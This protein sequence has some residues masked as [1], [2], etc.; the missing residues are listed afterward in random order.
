MKNQAIFSFLF[1]IYSLLFS[2]HATTPHYP[3]PAH[4]T[5]TPG[6][7]K[8]TNV[9]QQQMDQVVQTLYDQWKQTYLA[10]S[11]HAPDQM[12]VYYK[13]ATSDPKNAVCVSEGQGYGMIIAAFMAGYEPNAQI[14]F[15]NLFRYYQ[16]FPSVITAPLM[17]WQ[18]VLEEGE[19]IPNPDGGD[20]SA[21]DGDLDIAFALL[22]A[23]KQ[24]GSDN[25]PGS[26][27]YLSHAREI[28]SGILAGDVNLQVP[29]LKLGDWVSNC[30]NKFGKATRP[31]DFML[32][33][34]RNFSASS[35]DPGWNALLN[36]TYNI[37]NELFD[38]YSPNTGLMPDFS[39]NDQGAYIPA[40]ASFLERVED[41]YYSWNACRT[42]WRISLDYILAGDPRALDQLT[43]LNSWIQTKTSNN[44][45]NIKSGYKLDGMAL[46]SYGNLAF[47]TPFAVSAMINAGNQNWLN[48]LWTFTSS[49]PTSGANYFDNTLRLLCLIAVSGNWWTPLNLPPS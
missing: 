21:T 12:Y 43:Q 5:Y 26:I 30:D 16:A 48:Q 40:R 35:Q 2:L 49:K 28:M 8:P 37:I 13:D 38:H 41:G 25:G 45:A 31:S 42:P 17:G 6:V 34:L 19:I 15:D 27:D 46:V 1:S 20:D 29:V 22:L 3:F 14:I 36:K 47:S 11:P 4:N 7:I 24:W 23:D 18:Q 32:N 44:P 9:T 10:T 33:H 39:E